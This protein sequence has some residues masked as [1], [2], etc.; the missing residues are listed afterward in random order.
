MQTK[1]KHYVRDYVWQIFSDRSKGEEIRYLPAI[2]SI[3]A[4]LM[5]IHDAEEYAES[6]EM[7][8]V[9][10][11]KHN[12]EG[13]LGCA[14]RRR[15]FCKYN[16]NHTLIFEEGKNLPDALR[17]S[18]GEDEEKKWDVP[19]EVEKGFLVK[20]KGE[21]LYRYYDKRVWGKC[22]CSLENYIDILAGV[23]F[24]CPQILWKAILNEMDHLKVG[25]DENVKRAIAKCLDIY[26]LLDREEKRY[27]GDFYRHVGEIFVEI[28]N[29]H[30]ICEIEDIILQEEKTV[31][32]REDRLMSI[33]EAGNNGINLIRSRLT[34]NKWNKT[35]ACKVFGREN[36]D[37]L[38]KSSMSAYGRCG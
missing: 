7:T 4:D 10:C 12:C 21:V 19:L 29:L 35:D 28:S 34:E 36:Y 5:D 9:K 26:I 16:E 24:F 32:K 37:Y 25:N 33:S 14:D 13:G 20:I 22:F 38:K 31:W 2:L 8:I 15:T 3:S 27:G 18:N 17:I 23:F 30:R 11:E 1:D 6:C